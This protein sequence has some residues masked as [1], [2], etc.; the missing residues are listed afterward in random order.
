MATIDYLNRFPKSILNNDTATVLGK[1][2]G[3]YSSQ[4]DEINA[5]VIELKN[6]FDIYGNA[7]LP[8]D[9]IV[10]SLVNQ[11]RTPG[12]SDNTYRLDLF[13]AIAKKISGGTIPDLVDIGG[14][15][16]GTD[17]N[18][19]FRPVELYGQ[20]EAVLLDGTMLLDGGDPLAPTTQRSASVESTLQGGIDEINVPLEV[21]DA[22]GEIRAAGVYAKFRVR[23]LDNI[24]QMTLYTTPYTLLD[25]SWILD[26]KSLMDPDNSSFPITQIALG[27]GATREPQP[28]D[29]GLQNEVYRDTAET[30]IDENGQPFFRVVIDAANLNTY[31]IDEMAGFNAAGDLVVKDIFE[32]KPKNSSFVY[33]Y[34]IVDNIA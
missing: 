8:L 25:A 21:G 3:L 23:F 11:E 27:D 20:S 17:E 5:V 22:I 1:L 10:G 13:V 12:D 2:W 16:A 31:T 26:S 34:I 29:T 7:G 33:E 32:G 30:G 14:T 9:D 15:I 28:D 18:A 4:I 6:I 24:S 19:K